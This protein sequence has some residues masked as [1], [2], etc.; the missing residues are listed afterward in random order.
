LQQVL[1]VSPDSMYYAFIAQKMCVVCQPN[2]DPFN[3]D[4]DT[5]EW[6]GGSDWHHCASASSN[7]DYSDAAKCTCQGYVAYGAARDAATGDRYTSFEEMV[8][9][10]ASSDISAMQSVGLR[11]CAEA[12]TY[13]EHNTTGDRCEALKPASGDA[14]AKW[15]CPHGCHVD[16]ADITKCAWNARAHWP[17]GLRRMQLW[18]CCPPFPPRLCGPSLL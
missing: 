10:Y 11:T 6:G 13:V 14:A 9:G 12:Y 3:P 7:T 18:C 15:V 16:T 8:A 17:A 2:Y 1:A 4:H 5:P